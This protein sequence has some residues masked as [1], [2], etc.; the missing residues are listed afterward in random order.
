MFLCVA[1]GVLSNSEL[2]T[3]NGRGAVTQ[4]CLQ[5]SP[6]AGETAHLDL[7]THA[8]EAWVGLRVQLG[9]PVH[10]QHHTMISQVT[11]LVH[12]VLQICFI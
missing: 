4:L 5:V 1:A 12:K 7:D 8:G 9:G 10:H 11:L 6:A 2:F 3:H